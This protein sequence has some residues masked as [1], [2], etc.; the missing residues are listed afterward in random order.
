MLRSRLAGLGELAA[1]C[2]ADAWLVGGPVRDLL[3]GR[4]APD[5]DL[6]VEGPPEAVARAIAEELGGRV[7]K[8]TDF[9][10]ATVELP[11]G[12][13]IDI[14]RTRSECY[15]DPGALPEVAPAGLV[16]DLQRRDFTVN[17]MA[18][19]LAPER[20][21]ELVDPHGGLQ[22]LHARRLRVLHD[23]S[24]D[25]DPTR[26][27]RAA[28][29]MLRLGFELE[30]RTA[31]LM[32][33]AAEQRRLAELSGARLRNELRR[34]FRRAPGEAL[35]TLQRLDLLVAMGL[36]A[37]TDEAME[38]CGRLPEAETPL[39]L[40]LGDR[41][42]TAACL[43][44][45]AAFS[46][47]RA[48]G[49]AERLM[50]AADE[51]DTLVAAAEL[52]AAPPGELAGP[53]PDSELFFA[54]RGT[55]QGAAAALWT[56]LDDEQRSRLEHFWRDLRG[57][58]ADISGE[59]LKAAGHQPGPAFSDALAAA[60]AAKIDRRASAEEQLQVAL[61]MLRSSGRANG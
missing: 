25:D 22:D 39:G 55:S 4:A 50:L 45:Y 46:D 5:L 14:A 31:E 53:V 7:R 56:V 41:K 40:R 61:A 34:I 13:E 15:R 52:A 42:A 24:F 58:E 48:E 2:G 51:R 59:D 29:F 28:R 9:M 11:G 26:M 35:A 3:L 60:L 38:A 12:E 37:A 21:G 47:E 10:T 57:T 36:N 43:G 20:F 6:A 44:L 18:M 1:G 8:T 27:L 16:E 17:A 19:A 30:E 23:A 54:L 49:L 32:A 33:R